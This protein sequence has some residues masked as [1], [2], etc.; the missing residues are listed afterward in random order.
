MPNPK[1]FIEALKKYFKD[2]TPKATLLSQEKLN[3]LKEKYNYDIIQDNQNLTSFYIKARGE[4]TYDKFDINLTD[5]ITNYARDE[6]YESYTLRRLYGAVEERDNK[7]RRGDFRD[8]QREKEIAD[9]DTRTRRINRLGRIL[10]IQTIIEIRNSTH[11][12]NKTQ[13]LQEALKAYGIT[14]PTQEP[15]IQS[16]LESK[17]DSK[18]H[19][20]EYQRQEALK[21]YG[22]QHLNNHHSPYNIESKMNNEQALS[23]EVQEQ[24]LKTFN[25]KRLDEDFIPSFIPKVKKVLEAQGVNEI[26]LKSGSLTKLINENRLKYLDRIKPTLQEP[27]RIILQDENTIIFAKDFN[28]T[29]YFTS[30]ARD[31]SG[32]WIVRSNAPK[33][34]KGLNN[35]INKGGKEIYNSQANNQINAHTPYDDIADSNTKLDNSIIPQ[36]YLKYNTPTKTHKSTKRRR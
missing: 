32:E 5:Y 23:K 10:P 33:S 17:L 24:W 35:K 18:P 28:D 16:T 6:S 19:F 31:D 14:P 20:A 1:D 8:T 12:D 26:H 15:Q 34:E 13:R 4:S 21:V 36:N 29:K 22:A 2:D 27:D 11:K 30:V 3:T 7:N 9:R 25:L